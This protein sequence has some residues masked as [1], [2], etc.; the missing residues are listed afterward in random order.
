MPT[1]L[2]LDYDK[3]LMLF[4]GRA[5][6]ELADA[7]ALRLG[8]EAGPVELQTYASGEMY[9]RYEESVRGADVFVVQSLAGTRDGSLSL[10][11][12]LMELVL[13][14]DAAVGASAHRVIAV[15]DLPLA[16]A[17]VQEAAPLGQRFVGEE[18]IE[19]LEPDSAAYRYLT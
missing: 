19:V 17:A 8:V 3:R 1:H 6:N 14:V 7:I 13:M 2:P 5:S 10:N 12:A 11:D 15:T 16:T 18:H 4:A 9:C